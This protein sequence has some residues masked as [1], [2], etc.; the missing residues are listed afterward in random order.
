MD[1]D[2]SNPQQLTSGET[3]SDWPQFSADGKFVFYQHSEPGDTTSLWRVP[4]AGGVPAKVTDS[5]TVRP[6][7]SRDGKW[8]AFWQNEGKPRSPCEL[9]LF[10]LES[11]KLVKTFAMGPAVQVN[12]DS[13]LRWNSDSQSLTYLANSGGVDN[14][15]AQPIDGRPA[16]Q[17]TN[18]TDNKI[19]SFDWSREGTLVTSRGVSTSDVV[20]ISDAGP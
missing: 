11:A 5:C 14:V 10:S 2:G 7:V 16:K 1:R 19:F 15:W 8:L 13:I 4:A 9:V 3:E 20:L 18:F 17:V 6:A 12:W